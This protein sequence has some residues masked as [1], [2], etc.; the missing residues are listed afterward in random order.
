MVQRY[1]HP[2]LLV[3]REWHHRVGG[4][5]AVVGTATAGTS[6]Y[7]MVPGGQNV[8]L[9][10]AHAVVALIGTQTAATGKHFEVQIG[11]SSVGVFAIETN[12]AGITSSIGNSASPLG[13]ATQYQVISVIKQASSDGE[14]DFC[15]EYEVLPDSVL[16]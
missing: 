15:W 8:R 6:G 13:T 16:S 11:N 12:A 10:A 2:N 5:P 9:V 14:V 3:R 1:D 4:P 7:F